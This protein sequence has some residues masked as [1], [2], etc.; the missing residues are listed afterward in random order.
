[1][2]STGKISAAAPC[3]TYFVVVSG[4]DGGGQAR[5]SEGPQA[6]CHRWVEALLRLGQFRLC[7]IDVQAPVRLASRW[8]TLPAAVG[9]MFQ[10]RD[11]AS[12]PPEVA[13]P[14]LFKIARPL[15]V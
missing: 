12:V 15:P 9:S 13:N 14:L 3:I 1:M 10:P 2:I 4:V 7:V 11:D 5:T 8:I 6:A